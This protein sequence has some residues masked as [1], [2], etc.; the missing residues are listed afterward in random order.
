MAGGGFAASDL[1]VAIP[2]TGFA[3]TI[4]ML[5]VTGFLTADIAHPAYIQIEDEVFYYTDPPNTALNH[6]TSVTRAATDPQTLQQSIAAS[7]AIGARVCTLD[8]KAID[9]FIGYNISSTGATF[10]AF[11]AVTLVGKFFINMPKYIMWDYPWFSGMGQLV[12]FMLFAFSSGFVLSFAI[13]MIVTA[14]SIF[15]P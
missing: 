8:V 2:S 1:D 13:A 14:M 7:H 10:G 3:G 5:D 6:L 11:E 4:S 15:K 12:R 9:S